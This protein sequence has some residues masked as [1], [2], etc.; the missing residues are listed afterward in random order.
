MSNKAKLADHLLTRFWSKVDV[1][2]AGECWP[3]TACTIGSGYGLIKLSGKTQLAHRVA[4]S[5]V[6]L[7][8][9]GQLA[10]H[11]CDN[12]LCCNPDHIAWGDDSDNYADRRRR[13]IGH[14]GLHPRNE[15]AGMRLQPH[16]ALGATK[17][18]FVRHVV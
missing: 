4:R 1:R 12:R 8:Q 14:V 3:W 7:P 18:R 16:P 17:E 10:R 6:E 2:S 11:L 9:P 15:Q 5:T 13:K